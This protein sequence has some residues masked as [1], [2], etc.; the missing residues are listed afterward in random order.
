MDIFKKFKSKNCNDFV[1]VRSLP[2]TISYIII[3]RLL[4][5]NITKM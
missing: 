4:E 3:M 1:N 2:N 5:F